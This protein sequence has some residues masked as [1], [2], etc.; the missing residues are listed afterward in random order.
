VGR[1]IELL[2]CLWLKI[3]DHVPT[4][5]SAGEQLFGGAGSN[6]AITIGG[7]DEHGNDAVNDLTYVMLRATELVRLRDPNLNA[8]Y[9][10]GVNSRACAIRTRRPSTATKTPR[11]M[12]SRCGWRN[13]STICTPARRTTAVVAIA[14]ATGP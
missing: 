7:V 3:G 12:P 8:R 9:F 4:V 5:P 13:C 2:C 14:W 10:A 1:A 6:Q 11:P